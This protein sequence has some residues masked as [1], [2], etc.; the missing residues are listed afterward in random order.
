M[1][2]KMCPDVLR[3]NNVAGCVF[4]PE[5]DTVIVPCRPVR[6]AAG[7]SHAAVIVAGELYTWGKT[8]DGRCVAPKHG[9]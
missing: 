1:T 7:H 9:N 3:I 5:Q 4:K 6:I 8:D 2:C